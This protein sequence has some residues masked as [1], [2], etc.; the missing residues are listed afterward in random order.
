[1]AVVDQNVTLMTQNLLAIWSARNI[2]PAIRDAIHCAMRE[3]QKNF[4]VSLYIFDP[5]L[6][7][8][9]FLQ[10]HLYFKVWYIKFISAV[11]FDNLPT[12]YDTN[13]H[14]CD[15]WSQ[16]GFCG[17]RWNFKAKKCIPAYTG[18]LIKDTCRKS[19]YNCGKN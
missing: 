5:K 11:C 10:T 14:S 12:G 13:C 17:W 3:I 18:S 1:M 19:C 6:I 16:M 15:E 9:A 8:Q 7:R 2:S 4:A